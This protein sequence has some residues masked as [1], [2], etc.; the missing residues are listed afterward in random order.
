MDEKIS[1][2]EDRTATRIQESENRMATNLDAVK[3]DLKSD[4][5]EVK[6]DA[7]ITR[8]G[9]NLLLDWAE[10]AGTMIQ[11]PLYEKAQ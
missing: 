2:S 10:K 1:A 5:A 8:N 6:E 9:V 4:I 3:T 7:E 11:V